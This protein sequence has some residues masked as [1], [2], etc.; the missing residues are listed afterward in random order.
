MFFVFPFVEDF[1]SEPEFEKYSIVVIKKKVSEPEAY[2]NPLRIAALML[3]D[4][5]VAGR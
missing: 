3:T 1:D 4:A 2:P 5:S